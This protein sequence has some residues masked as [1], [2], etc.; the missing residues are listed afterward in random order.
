MTFEVKEFNQNENP[1]EMYTNFKNIV[2]NISK[3]KEFLQE[4]IEFY[5]R[6]FVYDDIEYKEYYADDG[7]LDELEALEIID[8][9]DLRQ[10]R[11]EQDGI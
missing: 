2:Y 6:V 9:D 4:N 1:D 8:T 10:M 3:V 5:G 11:G 7:E